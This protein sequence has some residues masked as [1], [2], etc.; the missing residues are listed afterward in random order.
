M[1]KKRWKI[2]VKDR[3]TPY[4]P[5]DGGVDLKT[6]TFMVTNPTLY[7]INM[8]YLVKQDQNSHHPGHRRSSKVSA[9]LVLHR[10][11]YL[12]LLSPSEIQPVSQQKT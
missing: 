10:L 9:F 11:R 6:T 7:G 4:G 5:E 2:W 3:W 8:V 1:E 12:R